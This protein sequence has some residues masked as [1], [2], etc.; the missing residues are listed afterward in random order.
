MTEPLLRAAGLTKHFVTARTGQVVRAVNGVGFEMFAGQTVGMVGESGSG[1]STVGRMVVRLLRPTEGVVTFRNR[2]IANLRGRAVRSLRSDLQMVF[3]DPWS[4]L[5]PRMRVSRLI[6]EPLLL[7][8]PLSRKER[9]ER[10]EDIA[11]SVRLNTDLLSRFPGELS[12]GQLQRVCIARAIATDPGLIVLDEPTS[13]LDLSVRA[14]ILDLL[15]ELREKTGAAMLFISH[16]LGTVRLVSDHILVLYLGHIVESG[17]MAKVFDEPAHPYTQTLLSAHLPADPK[18]ELH[19]HLLKGEIP[20]PID[21]PP[22]CPFSTRCPLVR[23]ECR[24]AL[25][26]MIDIGDGTQRAACIRIPEG[27]NQIPL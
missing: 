14:G 21:M 8:S 16:D 20:S 26:K 22:G 27:T 24:T 23:D 3:Q 2:E 12:G 10:A 4:S 19:R 17:P 11:R 1:K 13:S 7:H 25:P 5:N 15:Q 6:E 9:S 18:I